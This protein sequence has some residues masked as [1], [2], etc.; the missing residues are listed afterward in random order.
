MIFIQSF[1][2]ST[3]CYEFLIK[4]HRTLTH[5]HTH[6]LKIY[7]N[8][9]VQEPLRHWGIEALYLIQ[10]EIIFE[11]IKSTSSM[12]KL[13]LSP[14][15]I[16][17]NIKWQIDNKHSN[18]VFWCCFLYH[19]FWKLICP[20]SW[21]NVSYDNCMI[22]IITTIIRRGLRKYFSLSIVHNFSLAS[23]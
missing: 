2:T 12:N 16:S 7:M 6:T 23:V 14:P 19:F 11:L 22:T 8:P 5:T 3:Y 17:V 18:Y 9:C 13:N 10:L 4:S 20:F 1:C 21:M 15:E